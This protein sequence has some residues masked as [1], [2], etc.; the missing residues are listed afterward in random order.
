MQVKQ[1]TWF[2]EIFCPWDRLQLEPRIWR[3]ARSYFLKNYLHP[4][5]LNKL[6]L[7]LKQHHRAA[8]HSDTW[9]YLRVASPFSWAGPIFSYQFSLAQPNKHCFS[10]SQVSSVTQLSLN[11]FANHGVPGKDQRERWTRPHPCCQ[12][13]P[14]MFPYKRRSVHYLKCSE[15]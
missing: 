4:N 14:E 15:C 11:S 13:D 7:P 2:L 3:L 9:H 8:F 12:G 1:P 6:L 5:R 10:A